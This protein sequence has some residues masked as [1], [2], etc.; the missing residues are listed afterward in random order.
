LLYAAFFRASVTADLEYR[1]NFATRILT[2]IFWYLAQIVSFEVIFNHQ[3]RIGDWTRAEMRV[4]LGILFVVDGIYMVIFQ[5][6]LDAFSESVRKGNL[7]LLLTKPANSQFIISCQRASTAH[8]GNVLLA[9][10]WLGWSLWNLEGFQWWRLAW[11]LAVVPCGSLIFYAWRFMFSAMAVV[12]TRA[13]NLQYVWYHLYKLGMRPD[14]IYFP[15]L[16]WVVLTILPVGL[17]ASAQSRIVLGM[18]EP[19]LAA[20][21]VVV[22]ALCVYLSNRMLR[23]TLTYYSSASS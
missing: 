13:E 12:F 20:W 1:I 6:N 4:F 7:D 21:V 2:D 10:A 19:W 17:I 9:L 16:K 5:A 8:I 18:A 15:W 3:E 11:L 23:K 22:A 14:T